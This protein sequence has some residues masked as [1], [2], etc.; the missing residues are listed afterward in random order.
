MVYNDPMTNTTI[1]LSDEFWMEASPILDDALFSADDGPSD[2]WVLDALAPV[3]R[4][5]FEPVPV[6]V[7]TES[8]VQAL[9]DEVDYRI[10]SAGYHEDGEYRRVVRAL[11]ADR[12]TLQT[13]EVVK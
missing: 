10:D 12:V 9:L 6:E 8:T 1:T 11:L 13:V 7:L 2:D 4:Y 5:Q 3:A